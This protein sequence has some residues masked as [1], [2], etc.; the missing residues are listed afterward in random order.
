M[1]VLTNNVNYSGGQPTQTLSP[2]I[3]FDMPNEREGIFL[4]DDFTRPPILSTSTTVVDGYYPYAD[5]GAT[6]TS[7][8]TEV[9]GVMQISLDTTDNDEAHFTTGSNVS[10]L[11][12]VSSTGKKKMAFEA[13]VRFGGIVTQSAYIG[14][15]QEGSPADSLIPDAGTGIISKDIIGFQLKDATSSV[16]LQTCYN[17]GAADVGTI[18]NASALT[19][20]AATWYKLGVKFNGDAV[21]FYVN[22]VMVAPTSAGDAQDAIGILANA[23]DMPDGEELAVLFGLKNGGGAAHTLDIDW[24]AVGMER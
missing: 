4:F 13:R 24:Y 16:L 17:N 3:W 11:V 9:G 2:N 12:K 1:G 21:Y 7:L 18:H 6:I 23:T 14:L 8:A 22:G 19:I 15:M 5:S 20:V 10:G